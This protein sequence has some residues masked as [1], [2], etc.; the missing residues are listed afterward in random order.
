[1][2]NKHLLTLTA[3]GALL[4]GTSV[5]AAT[6]FFTNTGG[7]AAALDGA[8]SSTDV[9]LT[10]SSADGGGTINLATVNVSGG[11]SLSQDADK[12]GHGNTKWGAN[13]NWTFKFD[14]TISFDEINILISTD[15]F[16]L[17]STAWAGDANA[18]GSGWSFDGTGTEGEFSFESFT[19]NTDLTSAGVSNVP[20]GTEIGFGHFGGANGGNELRSFT[21]TPIPEPSATLL[22]ALG[23][24]ALLRRRRA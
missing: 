4:A 1:M 16:T 19:G 6:T 17:K 10:L 12:M 2:K 8:Q 24:L 3:A 14:Q 22:G 21:I 20:A 5:Q 18:S 11:E 7:N 9:D 13:Q 23:L 15:V